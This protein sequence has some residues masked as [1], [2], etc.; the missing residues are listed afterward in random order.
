MSANRP[1]VRFMGK[2]PVFG[3]IKRTRDAAGGIRKETA[4]G[5]RYT[6]SPYYLWWRALRLSTKYRAVCKKLGKSDNSKLA[7]IYKDFGD[8][9]ARDFA[10]WW[11]ERGEKLFG[12]PPAP[13]RVSLIDL[14]EID[15]YRESVQ[16]NQ[17]LAVAIPLFLTKREIA[18]SVRKLV[19]KKHP[20]KRGRSAVRTRTSISKAPYKLH[21]Y[22][23]I[24]A[25][26]RALD[27]AEG[28]QKGELLKNLARG[29]EDI[30]SVSRRNRM[31][32]TLI[33]YAEQGKFPVTHEP[34]PRRT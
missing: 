33:T 31:G 29:D 4:T 21:N 32:E 25:I 11:R 1:P 8:L 24:D 15:Q 18:S 34:K 7:Q 16:S 12:E 6:E 22:K 2:H 28:R 13:M 27:V 30:S 3:K 20:G 5:V 14:N 19:A 9:F 10:P 23:S 17:M 26:A